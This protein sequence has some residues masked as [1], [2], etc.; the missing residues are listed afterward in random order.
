MEVSIT[1]QPKTAEV[2][3]QLEQKRARL[4]GTK[5]GEGIPVYHKKASVMLDAW[6]QRNFRSSGGN[7]SDGKW[8]PFANGGRLMPDGV[9]DTSAKL[10]MDTG[11][12]RASHLPFYGKKDAG[13]GTE[14]DYA[15]NHNK[16]IGVPIRR[17]VPKDDEVR[18]ALLALLNQHAK[19]AT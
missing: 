16:G 2:L 6:V 4:V 13:V 10:L 17:T 14:L 7:L 3:R 11:L 18:S 12:L 8:K 1:Q 15:L 19:A 9:V 5:P